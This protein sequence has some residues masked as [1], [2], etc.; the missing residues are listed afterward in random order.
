MGRREMAMNPL[1]I[2][3][4]NRY[5]TLWT[6]S[7]QLGI[8]KSAFSLICNYHRPPTEGEGEKFKTVMSP[9]LFKKFFGKPKA[10]EEIQGEK[11]A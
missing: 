8:D 7:K 10:V 2:W 9:Y 3:F 1:K 6:A 11:V 5:G 4:L